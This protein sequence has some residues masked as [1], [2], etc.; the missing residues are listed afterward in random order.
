MTVT[1]EEGMVKEI[2]QEVTFRT[3]FSLHRKIW[4]PGDKP[5][6][7]I[8]RESCRIAARFSNL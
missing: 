4:K 7:V 6:T 3:H 2:K 8:R 1:H 5:V